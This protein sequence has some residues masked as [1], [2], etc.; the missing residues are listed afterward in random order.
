MGNGWWVWE[1]SRTPVADHMCITSSH[2]PYPYWPLLITARLH[3]AHPRSHGE[4]VP[5]CNPYEHGCRGPAV[6]TWCST[7]LAHLPLS[8]GQ[9]LIRTSPAN[10]GRRK[11][12]RLTC[13]R[14]VNNPS[15]TTL[16]SHAHKH[17][18]CLRTHVAVIPLSPGPRWRQQVLVVQSS[19]AI[20]NRSLASSLSPLRNLSACTFH[21]CQLLRSSPL[22]SSTTAGDT[23]PII[24]HNGRLQ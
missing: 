15:T 8:V 11:E 10:N 3:R 14:G 24:R 9:P 6:A 18:D 2:T 1:V 17:T 5:T 19:V 13:R 12:S 16:F 4:S 21:L 23:S 22:T 20:N 7:G